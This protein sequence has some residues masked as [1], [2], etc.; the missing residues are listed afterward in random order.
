MTWERPNGKKDAKALRETQGYLVCSHCGLRGTL[1][2]VQQGYLCAGC[3][4]AL[5]KK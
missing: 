3:I 5:A 4:V 1:R 2:K